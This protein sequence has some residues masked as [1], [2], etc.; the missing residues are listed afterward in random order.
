MFLSFELLEVQTSSVTEEDIV[1][2]FNFH[3]GGS[4]KCNYF[5][6]VLPV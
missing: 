2:S 1:G 5:F 4:A 6:C 3:L